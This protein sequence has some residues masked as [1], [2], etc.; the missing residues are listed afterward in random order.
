MAWAA[1]A[2]L[3]V[4][5]AISLYIHSRSAPLTPEVSFYHVIDG[6]PQP[7]P[8]GARLSPGDAVFAEI[9]GSVEMSVYVL[10]EDA[11]GRVFVLFPVPGLDPTNPL[12]PRIVHRL[13]GR[14]GGEA[15]SW[16]VTSVGGRET[17]LII[18]SR[19]PLREL[20]KE[21][22]GF[23]QA[24]PGAPVGYAELSGKTVRSLRGMGGILTTGSPKAG[25]DSLSDALLKVAGGK[26]KG[27]SIWISRYEF[28]NPGP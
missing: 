9:E 10:N 22:S 12:P 13:P 25:R 6:V 2:L 27:S 11:R 14:L 3:A 23:P 4:T 24:L 17:I 1:A 26:G 19:E 5:A 7:L 21:I 16:Q 18:A 15:A 20:E 8:P 28:E